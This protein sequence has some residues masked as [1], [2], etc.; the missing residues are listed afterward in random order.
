[1]KKLL[2]WLKENFSIVLGIISI[3]FALTLLFTNNPKKELPSGPIED[4]FTLYE[5]KEGKVDCYILDEG[6]TNQTMSCMKQE[7]LKDN[8]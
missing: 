4:R 2:S 5:D 3:L 1:M 8:Q 6:K 7:P